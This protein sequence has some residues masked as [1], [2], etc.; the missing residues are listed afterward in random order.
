MGE[1]E[2]AMQPETSASPR[3]A[4]HAVADPGELGAL[5]DELARDGRRMV[6]TNGC[7]DLLHVGHVRYLEQARA[8]GDALV[9]AING[10]ASVRSLKGPS[11]PVQ[12]EQERAEIL[13]ALGCV[14]HVVVFGS[15]RV[16]ELI[17]RIRPQ[18]YAKGGDYTP[19]TLH[20]E[21]RSALDECGC[22][23]NILPLVEG[24]STSST[25]A[26]LES[27]DPS[28]V[29][30]GRRPR[31]GILG[32]GRGSNFAA[33]VGAIAGGA[34]EAEIALVLSDREGAGI[35]DH[36][37]RLGLPARHVPAGD[38]PL[39]F[40]AAGNKEYADRLRAAGVD[41][42]VLAGFM[43]VL[44]GPMLEAFPGRIINIHPSLLPAYKGLEAWRQA[45]EDGASE[46]GCSVHLVNAEVD[47]GEVLAQAR[48]PVLPD[49]TAET[50]HAR[51]QEQ[52][53][54]LLPE[55][56]SQYLRRLPDLPPIGR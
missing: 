18:V 23:I 24:R 45:L 34:L 3:P 20:P 14:D 51:I 26:R 48:V 35:L 31:L 50:L 38:H 27:G 29:R 28:A 10:D 19:E 56:L 6:F 41:L 17:R 43:R 4:R 44:K 9:V 8:L 2:F 55:T 25:L 11:R 5:R 22:Q 16:T 52:E 7:F 15:E 53:H 21:E 39:R 37:R 33:L 12:P 40:D 42:V 13:A 36:A 47:G 32:S 54:R 49:D 46:T 1:V 30:S